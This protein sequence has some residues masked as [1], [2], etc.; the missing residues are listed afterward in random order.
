MAQE[1]QIIGNA[2]LGSRFY[3]DNDIFEVVEGFCSN[4][5]FCMKTASGCSAY[6]R[7]YYALCISTDRVDRASVCFKK[8]GE[9]P[10]L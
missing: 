3:V 9:V 4:C 7:G 10:P 2:P 8:V 5:T 1:R 6:E